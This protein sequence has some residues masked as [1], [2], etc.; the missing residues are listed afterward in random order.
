MSGIRVEA[1]HPDDVAARWGELKGFLTEA[2]A[3]DIEQKITAGGLYEAIMR[4]ESVCV[5]IQGSNGLLGCGVVCTTD[6][7]NGRCLFVQA[8]GG[9]GM[10]V[11]L[12]EFISF[13]DLICTSTGCTDGILFV[14]RPGW[15]PTLRPRGFKTVL[16]TMLK[17][18]RK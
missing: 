1:M 7:R 13:L 9:S 15:E 8:L 10:S 17:E 3:K 12:D 11:W 18:V 2:C 6:I 5:A 14:G 16:V 4:S